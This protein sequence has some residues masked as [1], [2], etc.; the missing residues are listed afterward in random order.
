M[1]RKLTFAALLSAVV[2]A[3][4]MSVTAPRRDDP[5]EGPPDSSAFCGV[6]GGSR[7]ECA[8]STGGNG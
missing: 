5:P 4:C 3:G 6:T 8:D 2:L 1:Q 7:T